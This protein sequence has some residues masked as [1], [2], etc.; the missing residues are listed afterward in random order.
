MMKL[1]HYPLCPRSRAIRLM[2]AETGIEVSLAEEAPWQWRPEFLA[3]NPAGELPVLMFDN[4]ISLCGHYAIAEF[5]AEE[6]AR[7]APEARNL[8]PGDAE[9]RA[10]VRR[11]IDWFH[12]K[13]E[14]EVTRELLTERV[15]GRMSGEGIAPDAEILRAARANLRY[16]MA[17]LSYLADQRRWL[18]GENLSLADLA[19][20]AHISVLDYLDEA[21]W[22]EYPMAKAWYQRMKS[23]PAFRA[24]LADKIAGLAP[25]I[26]YADLDF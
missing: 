14:R 7:L 25:S 13:F 20:A 3:I 21:V 24:I 5:L 22:T 26:A 16:H 15:Y 6:T 9:D 2:L 19:A 1:I 12:G 11:L 8:I 18:A 10:E 4:A 23:R 17:Y